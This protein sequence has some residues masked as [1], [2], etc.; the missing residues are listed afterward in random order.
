MK[1]PKHA[2]HQIEQRLVN[3]HV[4]FNRES[5]RPYEVENWEVS[6]Q[7]EIERNESNEDDEE[8]TEVSK[9]F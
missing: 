7:E 6:D 2:Q 9:T 1:T 8:E 3:R 5:V 4:R